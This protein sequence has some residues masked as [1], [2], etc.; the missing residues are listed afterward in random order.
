MT[1]NIFR[2]INPRLRPGQNQKMHLKQSG[3]ERQNAIHDAS[4]LHRRQ[5][6]PGT[7]QGPTKTAGVRVQT[8]NFPT[9]TQ[10]VQGQIA[11]IVHNPSTSATVRM[12]VTDR[13]PTS[14]REPG[15]DPTNVQQPDLALITKQN[16]GQFRPSAGTV[17]FHVTA[18]YQKSSSQ[19]KIV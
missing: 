13:A 6:V 10:V 16:L 7:S 11:S 15:R 3:P 2:H 4:V 17:P 18:F 12:T 9:R 1:A 19:T 8:N 14:T 5:S